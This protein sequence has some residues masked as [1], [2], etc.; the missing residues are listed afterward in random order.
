MIDKQTIFLVVNDFEPLRQITMGQLHSLGINNILNAN[1]GAKALHI[2]K[3]QPVD[4]VFAD[5]NIQ[6]MTGLD[7]LK[8]VRADDRLVQ[9]PF[10]MI[11]YQAQRQRVEEAIVSGVS[12]LLVN[13][14]T[15]GRLAARVEKALNS[16]RLRSNLTAHAE[17]AATV[18]VKTPPI[19]AAQ[20]EAEVHST[21]P[22]I[23]VVDDIADNLLL[24]SDLFKDDYRVR[25]AHNGKK[26]LHICQSDNPPDLVL[27]DIMMP[28]MDGFEVARLM[29][30]HP[31]SENIPVIFVTAMTGD[32][33][34][35]KGLELGAV[36]FVT[37]PIDP[38]VLKPQ[39]RNFMRYVE[40]HKQLQAEYDGMLALARLSQ[41]LKQI[42]HDDMKGPLGYTVLS[43]ARDY[44]E[45]LE[46]SKTGAISSAISQLM[47]EQKINA[48][49]SFAEPDL[50]ITS[51][52]ELLA[53]PFIK[54]WKNSRLL[55][56]SVDTDESIIEIPWT[57]LRPGMEIE[58]VYLGN[59][60]YVRHCIANPQ[61]IEYISTLKENT[62]RQP[63][64]KIWLPPK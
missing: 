16:S 45:H 30:E 52:D 43:V 50:D 1:S 31:V 58:S 41:D 28:G 7:L 5:W 63:T 49:K 61:V 13:P 55:N 23:L 54:S 59:K 32:E 26:A 38:L 47:A 4:I 8:A 35:I 18:E 53:L 11:I 60:P 6:D 12:D 22:N 40:R 9:L 15:T 2:L 36:D 29:R 46:G 42:S 39:V 10:I 17:Q 34:R 62:G 25:I 51:D 48:S 33:V 14:Y 20:P 64:V 27:L 37:K 21:R 24:L 57:Q 44:I 3:N 56:R 19:A